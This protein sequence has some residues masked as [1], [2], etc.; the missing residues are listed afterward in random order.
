[1]SS[2]I[3]GSVGGSLACAALVF[4]VHTEAHAIEVT[5]LAIDTDGADVVLTWTESDEPEELWTSTHPNFDRFGPGASRVPV[6]DGYA[7]D[8]GANDGTTRYYR[9]YSAVDGSATE[10]MGVIATPMNPGYTKIAFCVDSDINDTVALYEDIE[11]NVLGMWMWDAFFQVFMPAHAVPMP[12]RPGSV[13]AVYHSGPVEPG[14]YAMTGRLSSPV[15][16]S[17]PL[18]VGDNLVTLPAQVGPML[19]SEIDA[20]VGTRRIRVWDSALQ[21]EH[22]YPDDGDIR[23][24]PCT[25]F[26]VEVDTFGIWSFG[27]EFS[28]PTE[29][30]P[31][32]APPGFGVPTPP[33]GPGLPGAPELPLGG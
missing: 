33:P 8:L 24:E 14:F 13:V 25:G 3:W 22:I 20:T 16:M 7:A 30:A 9:L 10:T 27:V 21:Q 29:D 31:V 19:A 12:V 5:D 4:A 2:T 17:Q 28:G 26:H 18:S 6:M 15:A 32:L 1:M 11:S 23:I